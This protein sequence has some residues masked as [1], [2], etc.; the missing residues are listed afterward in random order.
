[1]ALSDVST[2]DAILLR[3]LFQYRYSEG[4]GIS[5]MTFGNLFLVALTKLLGSQ[6]KAI[7]KAFAILLAGHATIKSFCCLLLALLAVGSS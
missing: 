5:G 6:A 7:E 4:I 1:L 2:K 3:R